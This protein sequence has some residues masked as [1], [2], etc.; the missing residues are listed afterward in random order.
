MP[1]SFRPVLLFGVSIKGTN[2]YIPLL[3]F[4]NVTPEFKEPVYRDIYLTLEDLLNALSHRE[5]GQVHCFTTGSLLKRH[6]SSSIV[7]GRNDVIDWGSKWEVGVGRGVT[8][9]V[10]A[11]QQD[12]VQTV[13]YI[14]VGRRSAQRVD[15]P[16][17]HLPD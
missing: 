12:V 9:P 7:S 4:L 1:V 13:N 11:V 2:L 16:R 10:S 15:G 17:S 5:T 14:S 6:T 3:F 8:L